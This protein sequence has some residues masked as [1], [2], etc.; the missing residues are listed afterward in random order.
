MLS[1][2]QKQIGKQEKVQKGGNLVYQRGKLTTIKMFLKEKLN[3]NVETEQ[4][5]A[6]FYI[7]THKKRQMKERKILKTSQKDFKS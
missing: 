3:L 5:T 1:G 6:D 4:G 2:N 7:K